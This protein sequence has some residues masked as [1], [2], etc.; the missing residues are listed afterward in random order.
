MRFQDISDKDVI[1]ES[2]GV[3]L[4]RISDCYIDVA[5]GKVVKVVVN[6]GF[7]IAS[8][9]G[10]ENCTFIPWNNILKIGN[11]VIIV[12]SVD[13]HNKQVNEQSSNNN[14]NKKKQT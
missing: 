14:V 6:N 13:N 9:F 3:K 12:N 7:R 5:S 2:D 1:R 10:K 4:G 8:L 11:D